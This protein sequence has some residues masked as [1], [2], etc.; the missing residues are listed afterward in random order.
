MI[1][2]QGQITSAD[3]A[4]QMIVELNMAV[5]IRLLQFVLLE[6]CLPGDMTPP[7]FP[8]PIINLTLKDKL[9][10]GYGTGLIGVDDPVKLIIGKFKN[11][12]KVNGVRPNSA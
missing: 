6:Q 10:V 4:G 9:P 1:K 2:Y 8:Y 7:E 11:L 3:S 12:V 5:A